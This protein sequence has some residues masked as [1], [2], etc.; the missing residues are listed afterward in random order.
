[1]TAHA[2]LLALVAAVAVAVARAQREHRPVAIYLITLALTDVMRGALGVTSI[3]DPLWPLDC[4]LYLAQG[5]TFVWAWGNPGISV[6]GYLR[7]F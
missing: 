1:M 2:G 6:S 5:A 3:D 4:T 7:N